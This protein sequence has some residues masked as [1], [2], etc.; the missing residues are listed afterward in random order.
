MIIPYR[1]SLLAQTRPGESAWIE[2]PM[3]KVQVHGPRGNRLYN[4]RI[5]T[6]ADDTILPWSAIDAV[7]VALIPGRPIDVEGIGGTERLMSGWVDLEL[8]GD[9]GPIRWSCLAAFSPSGKTLFGLLGFLEH[10]VARFD[11]VKKEVRLQFRGQAP[12]P[13]FSPPTKRRTR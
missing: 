1:R 9:D 3:A 13:L 8:A 12:P 2:R 6:G 10:F 4:G 11:G 5:D 7:G